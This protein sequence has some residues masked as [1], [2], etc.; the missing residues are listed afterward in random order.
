VCGRVQAVVVATVR[1]AVGHF[2]HRADSPW[3]LFDWNAWQRIP[4]RVLLLAPG[5]HAAKALR[6][7]RRAHVFIQAP[8]SSVVCATHPGFGQRG[9]RSAQVGLGSGS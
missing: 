1:H 5:A 6:G 7:G 3:C 2:P 8:V 4:A 9:S